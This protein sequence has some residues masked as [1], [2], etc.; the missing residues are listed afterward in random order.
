MDIFP[1]IIVSIIWL[2]ISLIEAEYNKMLENKEF[3][4][5]KQGKILQRRKLYRGKYFVLLS[6]EYLLQYICI[7]IPSEV[8]RKT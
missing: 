8:I 2:K 7:L 4:F 5:L 1:D 3:V 6:L